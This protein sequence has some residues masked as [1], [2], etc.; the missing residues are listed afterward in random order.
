MHVLAESDSRR[1]ALCSHGM[2]ARWWMRC[3]A[4]RAQR[5]CFKVPV[6]LLSNASCI[7]VD[8]ASSCQ[9]ARG[10]SVHGAVPSFEH[11]GRRQ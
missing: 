9:R 7:A 8:R 6:C 3:V 10:K 4:H 5:K 1:V 2:A 11:L